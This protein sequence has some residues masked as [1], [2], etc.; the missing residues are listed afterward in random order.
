MGRYMIESPHTAED[1]RLVIKEVYAMG[2]LHHFEWGCP[3]G[4]HS[5]WAIVEAENEI[6][7]RMMV[8]SVI[9]NATRIVKL[10][11]FDAA[12]FGH[13]HRVKAQ[14]PDS[15]IRHTSIN[16]SSTIIFALIWM[17]WF[18]PKILCAW[19]IVLAKLPGRGT[20]YSITENSLHEHDAITI[21][22]A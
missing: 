6:H 20:K 14:N 21:F 5:G 10:V 2:Y 9:R 18:L 4:D 22:I 16:V 17:N 12:E 19:C 1:C 7:A 3:D 13:L 15:F 8:P 11:R